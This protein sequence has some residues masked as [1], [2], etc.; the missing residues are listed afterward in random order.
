MHTQFFQLLTDWDGRTV[1]EDA[2]GEE[3]IDGWRCGWW[4]GIEAR[5]GL[6]TRGGMAINGTSH[7]GADLKRMEALAGEPW[8]FDGEFQVDGTLTATKR[9]CERGWRTGGTAGKLYLFDGMPE[10]EWRAGGCAM[11]LIDRKKRLAEL[12]S[13]ITPPSGEFVTPHQGNIELIPH[14]LIMSCADVYRRADEIWDRDGEGIVIK[15]ANCPYIRG[16]S[17]AW[18]RLTWKMQER[19]IAA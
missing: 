19:R 9:W 4:R 16:R 18:S 17:K 6:W 3:K 15:D 12:I 5:P 13:A 1:P 14:R 10:R 7:I 11:P 2:I 8:M